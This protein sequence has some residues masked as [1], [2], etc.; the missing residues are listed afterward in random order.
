MNIRYLR[1]FC[2]I[3]RTRSFT[4]T[5]R[6]FGITQSAVS[7]QVQKLEREFSA[8]LLDR[9]RHPVSLTPAGEVLVSEGE[10]ILRRYDAALEAVHRASGDIAGRLRLVA[11]TIPAEY[12]LPALLAGFC[13][14]YPAV[15]PEVNVSDSAGVYESLVEGAAA[16]GF[17]GARRDD[18]G[19]VHEALAEDEV[20]LVS[21]PGMVA[22]DGD[23]AGL[24]AMPLVLREEGSG[25]LLTVRSR[26]RSA[27]FNLG[28]VRPAMRL[29]STQAVLTAVRAGA[30][31]GFVS[32]LAAASSLADGSLVEVHIAGLEI[33]RTLW[34]AYDAGR[35]EGGLRRA[36]LDHLRE[37][38]P[39]PGKALAP[40][41][42]PGPGTNS[43]LH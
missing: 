13:R 11:S 15:V 34:L 39:V 1:T 3:A 41:N 22:V 40:G 33:R 26:L 10:A 14:R 24:A 29:G 8:R 2:S 12:L 43:A 32:R 17:T 38:A 16:F 35:A 21:A 42:A 37:H 30:G 27:G 20:V 5:A 6:A 25:T 7:L 31:A 4:E 9:S 18:L 19:L 28:E 36:F 23:V